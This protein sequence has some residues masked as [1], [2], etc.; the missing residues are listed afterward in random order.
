MILESILKELEARFVAFPRR[1]NDQIT[2]HRMS[3][4]DAAIEYLINEH[5]KASALVRNRQRRM[6]ARRAMVGVDP[7]GLRA[8]ANH[9]LSPGLREINEQDR[10]LIVSALQDKAD[11]LEKNA[12]KEAN[13]WTPDTAEEA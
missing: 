2:A 4:P 10:E 1:D 12:L 8:L 13:Q 11:A 3:S 7:S 5:R 9:L 6:F